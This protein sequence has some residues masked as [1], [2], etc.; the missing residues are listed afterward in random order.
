MTFLHTISV[1]LFFS[2]AVLWAQT[3]ACDLT[4]DG[5][6]DAADVQQA[7]NMS[8]GVTPCNANVAGSG[9]CNVI[10]TQR[11]INSA[12]GGVCVTGSVHR[13]VL[14]WSPSQSPNVVSYNV[15]RA[16]ASGGPFTRLTPSPI[17]T[18]S[19]TDQNVQNGVT[20]YYMATAVDNTNTESTQSTQTSAVVPQQ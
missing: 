5:K 11:V 6:V 10:V 15:Y 18:T 16:T 19:Y 4:Q 2:S 7:I 8:L 12:L 3:S 20:Y 17:T 13:V 9:V 1:A 14:T